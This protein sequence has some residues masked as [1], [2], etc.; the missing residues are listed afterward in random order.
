[1]SSSSSV[2]SA[3]ERIQRDIEQLHRQLTAETSKEA[4]FTQRAH[5][6][7]EQAGRASS[8]SSVQMYLREA[9]RHRRDIISAQKKRADITKRIADKTA[10]LH[11]EQ[12]RLFKV[13]A[14]EHKDLIT[15][16]D[17]F[18]QQA[19]ARQADVL[20][21]ASESAGTADHDAFISHATEDKDSLAR[22][23]AEALRG[24][25]FN[26]WYDE[27]ALTVGDSLRRSIDRGLA[28]SRFGIVILSPAFFAKQWPQ[29]ELDGLVAKEVA[30]GKVILP[31]WHRVTKDDV[32]NYS[33]T[34]ADRVAL[35][36]AT[37]S[38]AEIVDQLTGVLR[39]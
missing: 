4:D 26:V 5:R 14:R 8:T 32:L 25:G 27:F 20:A 24:A 17:S 31:L 35:N 29:Y 6:A 33:P 2:Q 10:D 3:I 36:T 18:N 11:R 16:I 37:H 22:P 30:G 28:G 13:Q 9:D 39:S 15:Q 1:M 23:L 21:S 7:A 34:L 38:L 19:R 12:Q